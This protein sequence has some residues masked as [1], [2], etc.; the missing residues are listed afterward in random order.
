[1]SLIDSQKDVDDWV[2][3]FKI[4]YFKPLEIM[5]AIT[6]E[7]GELAKEVNNRFGPRTK[8]SPDD[9]AEL[10]EELTDVL[11]NLICMANSQNIN[12]EEAWKKKMEKQH[13]RD[14]NRFE[15]KEYL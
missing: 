12:L 11:F 7:V 5:S 8:K 1:M 13:G 10:S 14:K 15:R 3:Q 4:S 9:K 6:E 2:T